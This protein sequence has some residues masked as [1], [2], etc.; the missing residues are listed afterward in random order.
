[1][2]LKKLSMKVLKTKYIIYLAVALLAN[3]Q[4]FGQ[5]DP[6]PFESG[7]NDLVPLD[8]GLSLLLAAGVALGVKKAHQY[9]KA[10]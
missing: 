10:K 9:R 8:G 6:P 7:V 1:M 5:G 4:V 3:V 2:G